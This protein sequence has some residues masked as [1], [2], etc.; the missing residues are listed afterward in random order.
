MSKRRRRQAHIPRDIT[1]RRAPE[2]GSGEPVRRRVLLLGMLPLPVAFAAGWSDEFVL[3]VLGFALVVVAVVIANKQFKSS[4]HIVLVYGM[5]LLSGF[6]GPMALGASVPRMAGWT[7]VRGPVHDAPLH[8]WALRFAFPEARVDLTRAGSAL[9]TLSSGN[10]KRI[11]YFAAPIVATAPGADGL[12]TAF[13]MCTETLSE[14]EEESGEV[15]GWR[16]FK[17]DFYRQEPAILDAATRHGL[18]VHPDAVLLE[19]DDGLEATFRGWRTIGTVLTLL[20]PV[21]GLLFT[22]TDRRGRSG[23]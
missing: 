16:A 2:R 3:K 7:S 4:R 19:L 18:R 1:P 12:V 9:Y 23:G 5:A 13:S 10:R 14:C 21:L 6:V 20:G 8:G 17:G 11:T 22:R 15:D